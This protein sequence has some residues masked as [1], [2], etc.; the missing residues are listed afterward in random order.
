[1]LVIIAEA[2]VY[3][4]FGAEEKLDA[5]SSGTSVIS[6]KCGFMDGG[7]TAASGCV[8]LPLSYRIV[9]VIVKLRRAPVADADKSLSMQSNYNIRLTGM[10]KIL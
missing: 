9:W 3:R 5:P 4:V 7:H 1:V 6:G 10:S 8:D 2:A